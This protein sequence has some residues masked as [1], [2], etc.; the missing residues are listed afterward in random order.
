MRDILTFLFVFAAFAGVI[1]A[2]VVFF[3]RYA[4]RLERERTMGL[5]SSATMLGWQ[6]AAESPLDYFPNLNAF[7]LF[8]EGH[9]KQIKNLMYG[10]RNGVKA[11]LFD[12]V[13]VVGH[14]KH[15]HTHYQSVAYFEPRD[16]SVP[17]FSL[18][19]ENVWHKLTTV[20]GYQ[21][22]DFSNRPTFSSAYLLRGPEE[23]AIRNAFDDELLGFYETNPGIST[24]GGGNQLFIFRPGHRTPPLEA[25]SFVD[26]ASRLQEIFSRPRN[27]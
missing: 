10:E 15:R 14:G 9:T 21:D 25:R 24:D 13:Y 7:P 3:A 27:P 11:A 20:L 6:F 16:L 18:R 2:V 17:F 4:K 5:K 22:I 26:L 12:Y 19:P 23:Q 1:I 8:S